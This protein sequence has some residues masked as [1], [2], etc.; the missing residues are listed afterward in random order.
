M[1]L[2]IPSCTFFWKKQ[3][4][5]SVYEWRNWHQN[6]S[7][8][9]FVIDCQTENYDIQIN[10][11]NNFASKIFENLPYLHFMYLD[12]AQFFVEPLLQLRYN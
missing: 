11:L 5:Q 1:L 9:W 10:Y 12:Q 7:I 2:Y 3:I 4:D 8:L 6:N